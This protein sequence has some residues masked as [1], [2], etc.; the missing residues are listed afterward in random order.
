MILPQNVI[1]LVRSE[2]A[3]NPTATGPWTRSRPR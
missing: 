1:P 3:Q 2:V